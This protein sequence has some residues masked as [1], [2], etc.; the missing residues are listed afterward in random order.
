MSDFVGSRISLKFYTEPLVCPKKAIMETLQEGS[1]E[2]SVT[3]D[4]LP[5]ASCT[6]PDRS[7]FTVGRHQVDCTRDHDY[8]SFEIIV[9]GR[10]DSGK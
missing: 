7:T 5:E 4:I 6:P 3:Y 8:C 1:V 9:Q 10:C 2:T